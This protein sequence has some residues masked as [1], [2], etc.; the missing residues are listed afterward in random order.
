MQQLDIVG[1]SFNQV[2]KEAI[3]EVVKHGSW[4]KP[5]GLACLEVLNAR[6]TLTNPLECLCTIYERKL[7]YAFAVFEK[8]EY[9]SGKSDP[10][11]LKSY[12]KNILAFLNPL[13]N[14]FD[15]A[16]GPRI[17]TQLD[18]CYKL[19]KEDPDTRQAVVV[20]NDQRDRR[21]SKD[22][23]CTLSLQFLL[24]DGKLNLTATMRSNDLLWGTPYDINGFCFLQEVLASWL[25][26][27]VGVY[28]HNAGSL[29]LYEDKQV[30]LESCATSKSQQF[31]VNPRFRLSHDDTE[32]ALQRFWMEE[33]SIRKHGYFDPEGVH[34]SFIPYLNTLREH[35]NKSKK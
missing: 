11:A 2:Y 9:L 20:I 8:F 15:G 17:K 21:E 13:T 1:E 5:R 26:V 4:V 22:I 35:V 24:R 19:L 31:L 25:G 33:S 10:V 12:N 18:W 27:S 3:K 34:N 14:Q 23:P 7:N 30:Q 16:Y 29:H 6:L 28:V 32:E